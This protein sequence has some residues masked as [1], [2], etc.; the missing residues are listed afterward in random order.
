MSI[1]VVRQRFKDEVVSGV[2]LKGA[3]M[4]YEKGGAVQV[5]H[6]DCGFAGGLEAKIDVRCPADGDLLAAASEAA[7]IATKMAQR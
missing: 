2:T 1:T 3:T 7:K 4:T 6:F 5:F